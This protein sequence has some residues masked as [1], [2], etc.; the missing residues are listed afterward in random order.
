MKETI[1]RLIVV[2]LTIMAAQF[3]QAQYPRFKALVFYSHTVEKDHVDFANVAIR[4][5]KD[6]TRGNGYQLDTTSNMDDLN[7]AKL[8]DYSVVMWLNDFPH[9]GAQREAFQR[10][11]ENGGGW[12][13]FHVAGYN[14][15]DTSWP[16]FVQFLGGAVFYLNNWPPM[17][18]KI[19]IEDR[20]L[21]ITRGIPDTYFAPINEWYQWKPSPRLDKDV[22]V[23]ASLSEENY[24]M[25]IKHMIREGDTPVMWTNTRYRMVYMNMGHTDHIFEE[26]VQNMLIIQ[27]FRFV[28]ATDKKGNPFND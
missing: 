13:G 23:L 24:P 21:P 4:F 2:A 18:A 22:K 10:Y 3:A 5:F 17:P 6:L 7:D 11:M 12:L 8:K 16:W 26:A 25:G 9:T 15:K 1:P 19:V 28:A 14:D 27:A 20:T